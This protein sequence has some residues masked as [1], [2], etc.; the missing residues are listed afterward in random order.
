MDLSKIL[1][2]DIET[3]PQYS[4]YNKQPERLKLLW[5]HKASFLSKSEEDTPENLYSR[6]GIYAEFGKIVC[7][8]VG[9]I[10]YQNGKNHLNKLLITIQIFG[11][12]MILMVC[13]N[14]ELIIMVKKP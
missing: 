2:L 6:A 3:V 10:H 7:I 12:I 11:V 8:S 14:L 4:N 1:F 13:W 9:L 5:N